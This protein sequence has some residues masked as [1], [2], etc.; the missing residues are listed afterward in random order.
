MAGDYG[1][2]YSKRYFDRL[3]WLSY[4]GWAWEFRRRLPGL[5]GVSRASRAKPITLRRHDG[6]TLIRLRTACRR[7][8][9]NGLHFLPDPRLSAYQTPVFWLPDVMTTN[10]EAAAEIRRQ[11]SIRAEPLSWQ[12]IP[13]RKSLLLVP[14]RRT[15]LSI[16]A[17][18]YAAQVAI[19]PTTA[20][21]PLAIYLTL[22]VNSGRKMVETVRCLDWFA[23]HCAG[24]DFE[25][26]PRRGYAPNR[27]R[28]A[29]IALDGS[30]AGATQRD[31]A[32]AV[33]GKDV[34]NED[35]ENGVHSYKSRTRRL[36][37]KGRKLMEKD[38]LNLL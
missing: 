35:W 9:E 4:S 16:A 12:E 32:I 19:D 26:A 37:K 22:K 33:F 15:K 17:R 20:P 1:W 38:Y 30:L 11:I 3:L 6:V 23:R 7:A 25:V 2:N 28:N 5:L 27:L 31:I 34:V 29:L 24:I 36:I 14:G 13:G 8:E 18:G 21:I 10:L